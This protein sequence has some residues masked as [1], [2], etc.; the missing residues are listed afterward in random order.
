M[1][2]KKEDKF[3]G[4]KEVTEEQEDYEEDY[5]R[6]DEKIN[7]KSLTSKEEWEQ[8]LRQTG[9]D[10]MSKKFKQMW[11]EARIVKYIEENKPKLLKRKIKYMRKGKPVYR[12]PTKKWTKEQE[13]YILAHPEAKPKDLFKMA[14]FA[15]RTKTSIANKRTRMFRKKFEELP[16]GYGKRGPRGKYSPR[17]RLQRW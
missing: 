4:S 16:K 5:N 8:K 12:E 7:A 9:Y 6:L 14:V 11:Y 15:G 1:S 17:R 2:K 13:E 10:S 3:A